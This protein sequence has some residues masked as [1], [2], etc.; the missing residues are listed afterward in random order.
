[1]LSRHESLTYAYVDK[2]RTKA[3]VLR[4][5]RVCM[6]FCLVLVC[7]IPLAG[8]DALDLI[9][10]ASDLSLEPPKSVTPTDAAKGFMAALNAYDIEA[11]RDCCDMKTNFMFDFALGISDA[12]L[13]K[14]GLGDFST[15]DYIEKIVEPSVQ[16]GAMGWKIDAVEY[17]ETIT[18]DGTAEVTCYVTAQIREGGTMSSDEGDMTLYLVRENG[19]WKV[20]LTN[21]DSLM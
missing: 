7:L 17:E 3:F 6:S 12:F 2:G 18:G 13:S 10:P 21:V 19:E 1:M 8:C 14:I 4:V 20:D 16:S 9:N 5:A 11:I 15:A